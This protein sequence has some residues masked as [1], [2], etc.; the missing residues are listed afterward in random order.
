MN[1]VNILRRV[2]R[3]APRLIPSEPLR[4]KSPTPARPTPPGKLRLHLLST[5]FGSAEEAHRFCYIAPGP[6]LP[7]DLTREL[8]GAFID[9]DEVEMI[10]GDI[11]ARLAEFLTE[12]EADDIVLRMLGDNTLI[13]VTENAFGGL[14][15]EL[16]DTNR[17]TYLGTQI[18][19]V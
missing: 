4:R 9:T 6:D 10:H 2:M 17:L 11:A 5:D 12:A 15:Y 13:L 16:E 7:V 8:A 3:L 19:E 18:V 1:R 14:P